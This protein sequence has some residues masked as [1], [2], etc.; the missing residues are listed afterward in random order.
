[1]L[2]H[3]RARVALSAFL[4]AGF[5]AAS[6]SAQT[7]ISHES[8]YAFDG[9]SALYDAFDVYSSPAAVAFTPSVTLLGDPSTFA[10]VADG[11]LSVSNVATTG[12]TGTA[13]LALAGT[14]NALAPLVGSS[15]YS[16]ASS[17]GQGLFTTTTV[18]GVE[19]LSLTSAPADF[20]GPNTPYVLNVSLLG[21]FTTDGTGNLRVN[22]ASFNV[23]SNFVVT[24]NFNY[25]PTLNITTFSARANGIASG[26][27]VPEPG[28]VALLLGLT[29]SAA[30][31]RRRRS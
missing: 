4:L 14:G 22:A 16:Y 28:N 29:F 1:M 26:S 13:S 3:F 19:T 20:A 23:A 21:D 24:N 2:C 8:D 15:H 27:F 6:A 17:A 30:F 9:V 7:V 10:W 31:A 5:G 11:A 18:N 25:D 12:N